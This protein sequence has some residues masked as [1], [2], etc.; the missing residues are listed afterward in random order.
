MPSIINIGRQGIATFASCLLSMT[1]GMIFGHT[2]VLLPKLEADEEYPYDK[3]YDS[4]IASIA[5]LAMM[6]GCVCGGPISDAIGRRKGQMLLTLPY[7][8][9]WIITGTAKNN[10]TML[11]GRFIA[12]ICTGAVR[13]LGMV[14]IGE[15]SDPKYRSITL[16][17]PAPAI[18]IGTLIC[19]LVGAHYPW[20]IICFVF[21]I[22]NVICFIILMF[23]KESP[24]WLIGKGQIELGQ[25][26]Y[27]WF[28]GDSQLAQQELMIILE[29]QNQET[30]S[31]ISQFKHFV[32]TKAFFKS[33]MCIFFVFVASQLNGVNTIQFYA[34]DIFKSTF[35]TKVDAYVLMLVT[36]AMRAVCTLIFCLLAQKMPRK[37]TFLFAGFGTS[38]ALI[39]LVVYLYM[40][41]V[42]L[43]WIA[44]TCL[45]V[46]IAI[47]SAVTTVSWSF[48]AELFPSRVRGFGSGLSSL[49]SFVLLFISVKV[50]P[51][52]MANFGEVVMYGCFAT[53]TLIAIIILIFILPETNGRSL[54]DIEN[55]LYNK[56]ADTSKISVI[57]S[58]ETPK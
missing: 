19:H 32:L 35:G 56:K 40:K 58:D 13:P 3:A 28:R 46:Y 1:G 44:V 57:V 22:P 34:Q 25:E 38:L 41:P 23:L 42:G 16:C 33:I 45:V 26:S 51:T 24:L 27:K 29:S 43:L 54:Q 21:A 55:T 12:G 9:S 14:Y 18:F 30:E 17:S 5:P 20:R 49:I 52:I 50:T 36:D 37:L 47:A 15:I 11:I 39:G 4:W 31:F 6:I 7:T 8:L 10:L 53:V 48:I 2:A